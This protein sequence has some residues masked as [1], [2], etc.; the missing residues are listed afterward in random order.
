MCFKG[1]CGEDFELEDG[2]IQRTLSSGLIWSDGADAVPD[3]AMQEAWRE[4][5]RDWERLQS[6]AWERDR[7]HTEPTIAS[8]KVQAILALEPSAFDLIDSLYR[9]FAAEEQE[10]LPF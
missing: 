6:A 5:K 3:W 4:F 8:P 7:R 2:C 1:H 9:V 10:D